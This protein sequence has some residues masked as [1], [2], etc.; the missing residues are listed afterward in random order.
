MKNRASA[1]GARLRP[2]PSAAAVVP[3]VLQLS[4]TYLRA[5]CAVAEVTPTPQEAIDRLARADGAMAMRAIHALQIKGSRWSDNIYLPLNPCRAFWRRAQF[6]GL[7]PPHRKSVRR[8]PCVLTQ[9][10][11]RGIDVC[12]F[13]RDRVLGPRNCPLCWGECRSSRGH[14]SGRTRALLIIS[15][16]LESVVA[17]GEKKPRRLAGA[18]RFDPTKPG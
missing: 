15:S 1:D 11:Y 17:K 13:Q 7:R 8:T 18:C 2:K 9:M 3:T 4:R 5:G 16:S 6:R 14:V 10:C 12:I